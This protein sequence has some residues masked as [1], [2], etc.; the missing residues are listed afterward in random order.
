MIE[1]KNA[2][3]GVVIY[4][5]HSPSLVGYYFGGAHLGYADFRGMDLR[6]AEFTNAY[7]A[8]AKFDGASVEGATFIGAIGVELTTGLPGAFYSAAP[9]APARPRHPQH[10]IDIAKR[11]LAALLST[12]PEELTVDDETGPDVYVRIACNMADALVDEMTARGWLV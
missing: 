6:G 8:G 4:E 9:A 3:S 12:L 10:R 7:I 5:A 1:I 11:N 2:V